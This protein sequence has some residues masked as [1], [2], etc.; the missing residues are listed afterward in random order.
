MDETDS[1]SST[2]QLS[3]IF[4]KFPDSDNLPVQHHFM[5][6]TYRE[7]NTGGRLL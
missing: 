3:G 7:G 4:Q 5:F 1:G 2:V 6:F